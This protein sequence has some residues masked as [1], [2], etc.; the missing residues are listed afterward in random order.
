MSANHAVPLSHQ[1]IVKL[2][3]KPYESLIKLLAC[4]LTYS[5][6]NAFSIR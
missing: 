3:L 1:L 6:A 4:I 5:S 2:Y